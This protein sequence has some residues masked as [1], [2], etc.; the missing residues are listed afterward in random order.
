MMQTADRTF[1]SKWERRPYRI[2]VIDDVVARLEAAV[3]E[4]P[5]AVH[6]WHDG[7]AVM[8][9]AVPIRPRARVDAG[10]VIPDSISDD[11]HA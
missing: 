7:V 9:K 5:V 3:M 1:E 10:H 8:C 2:V 6:V 4:I 11:L